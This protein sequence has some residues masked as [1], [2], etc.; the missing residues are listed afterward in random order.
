MESE[1]K[2]ATKFSLSSWKARGATDEM[3]GK[4]DT[5]GWMPISHPGC[6]KQDGLVW[7]DGGWGCVLDV[8]VVRVQLVCEAQTLD[9]TQWK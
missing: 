8:G 4:V 1:K 9:E 3:W 6:P 5:L 2:E 7:R